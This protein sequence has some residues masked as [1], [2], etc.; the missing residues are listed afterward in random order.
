M[1]ISV[2]LQQDAPLHRIPTKGREKVVLEIVKKLLLM[3][4]INYEFSKCIAYF[5]IPT[6]FLYNWG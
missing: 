6:V 3:A 2:E 1:S 5:N 4:I